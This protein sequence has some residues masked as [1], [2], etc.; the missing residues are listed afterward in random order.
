MG[1]EDDVRSFMSEVRDRLDNI[2][3]RLDSVEK[4]LDSVEKRLDSVEKRLDGHDKSI[5]NVYAAR[6]HRYVSTYTMVGPGSS[7]SM[8]QTTRC[9]VAK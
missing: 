1:F 2:E 8:G 7:S 9:L 3:K 5:M 6:P 4:R